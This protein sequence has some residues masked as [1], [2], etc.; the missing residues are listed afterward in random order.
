MVGDKYGPGLDSWPQ[1]PVTFHHTCTLIAELDQSWAYPQHHDEL[2]VFLH[3]IFVPTA[4]T[5][6]P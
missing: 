4:L 3:E 6:S 2:W 5:F 1:G